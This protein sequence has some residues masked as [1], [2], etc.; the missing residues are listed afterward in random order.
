M[1]MFKVW[2][3]VGYNVKAHL[4]IY[5]LSIEIDIVTHI[6]SLLTFFFASVEK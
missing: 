5:N 6:Y 1:I 3:V 4:M 2:L